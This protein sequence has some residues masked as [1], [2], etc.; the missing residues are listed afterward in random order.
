MSSSI[1]PLYKEPYRLKLTGA[2]LSEPDE[3]T[4]FN[5]LFYFAFV[6]SVFFYLGEFFLYFLAQSIKNGTRKFENVFDALILIC[7][8]ITTWK[9]QCH[10]MACLQLVSWTQPISK[11]FLLFMSF[12][13][14][15]KTPSLFRTPGLELRI[16]RVTFFIHLLIFAIHLFVSHHLDYGVLIVWSWNDHY[17]VK[18]IKS[19][20]SLKGKSG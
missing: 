2:Q 19:F 5:A 6:F 10:Y 17:I 16:K 3:R 15:K 1:F 9:I 13:H 4:S 8:Y 11:H 7:N 14:P 18:C 12:I 20:A